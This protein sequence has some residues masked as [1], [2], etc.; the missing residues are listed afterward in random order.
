MKR[1]A[2]RVEP[3]STYLERRQAPVTP[4]VRAARC[5]RELCG[6]CSVGVS[7]AD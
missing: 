5:C 4:V 3:L 2:I 6:N 1:Q 7:L